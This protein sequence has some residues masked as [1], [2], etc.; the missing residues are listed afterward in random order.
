MEE[1][2]KFMKGLD[3]LLEFEISISGTDSPIEDARLFC[4]K[5]SGLMLGY[6]PV[7][8]KDNFVKF[9]VKDIENII[10]V[11]EEFGVN[12][13][14]FIKDRRF[15]PFECK[16][17]LIEPVKVEAKKVSIFQVAICQRGI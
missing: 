1:I 4:I 5:K 8:V 14:V 15:V 11:N 13:E 16:G 3:N 17:I 9:N 6:K 10:K 2:I 12:L 7:E